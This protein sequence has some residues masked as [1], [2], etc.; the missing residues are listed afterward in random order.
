MKNGKIQIGIVGCGGIANGKH[1]PALAKLGDQCDLIAFCDLVPE[2][3]ER[4]KKDYGTADARVF[5]DY[6]DLLNMDEID[7]IHVLTPNVSHCE[8]TCAALNAGKHVMCEK[9]MAATPADARRMIEAYHKSGKKLTIG[10]QNRFRDD[11][12]F[13]KKYC[14]E[15]SLGE[16]YFAKAYALRRRGVPTW[17]VFT[18]KSKQGGGPLIDIGT[19]S[20]DLALWCMDCYKPRT[21]LGASY[22]KLGRLL[23]PD[24]Q[25]NGG[26][27][28]DNAT[29]DVEDSAFG[30]IVMDNGASIF[31][32]SS[33]ALNIDDSRQAKI[34]LCGTKA[35]SDMN[36]G[37]R[38]NTVMQNKQ[39][40]I[41]PKTDT[42]RPGDNLLGGFGIAADR[43][44]E[45]WLGALLGKNELVV[46]PEQAIVVTE[47]L[48]AIYRS[49]A[50]KRAI[51]F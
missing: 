32:Q 29:Y 16:I 20:L 4:A 14:D 51:D 17:G 47:I 3:A 36:D 1:F 26:G 6:H 8:I 43:E 23:A 35:G 48:D 25:G 27:S 10:Y 38:I 28:W 41:L 13:L 33:W 19:H 37:L 50:E 46:K 42:Y 7:E 39:A 2:R 30:Y 45:A 22:E 12:L 24:N 49:S 5:T 40:M 31:L 34:T 44:S 21:V 9:P 18:D 11:S 15:G